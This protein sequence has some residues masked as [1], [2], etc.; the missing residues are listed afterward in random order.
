MTSVLVIITVHS[1]FILFGKKPRAYIIKGVV[2]GVQTPPKFSDFFLKSEGKEVE[3]EKK[4]K[5]MG[6]GGG[7]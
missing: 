4:W 1:L 5:E 2:Q 7:N 3:R 6:G